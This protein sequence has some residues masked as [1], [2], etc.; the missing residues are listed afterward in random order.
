[1]S[2]PPLASRA[3]ERAHRVVRRVSQT[4]PA[5]SCVRSRS[6]QCAST[7]WHKTSDRR[8]SPGPRAPASHV[9]DDLACFVAQNRSYYLRLRRELPLTESR[10][11]GRG[12]EHNERNHR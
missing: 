12:P 1:M 4:W 6:K 10:A 2:S 5:Q 9:G 3:S 11:S 7:A 8:P